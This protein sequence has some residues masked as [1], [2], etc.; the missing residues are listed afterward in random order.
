MIA[1]VIKLGQDGLVL[2]HCRQFGGKVTCRS[3]LTYSCCRCCCQV[4][5]KDEMRSKACVA[6][7]QGVGKWSGS[8]R[9]TDDSWEQVKFPQMFYATEIETEFRSPIY[10][11]TICQRLHTQDAFIKVGLLC[12]PLVHNEQR[13]DC[14]L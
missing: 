8:G 6:L 7:S 11:K 10:W 4:R 2:C 14:S 12:K 9:V 13:K 5:Q 1:V 3:Y